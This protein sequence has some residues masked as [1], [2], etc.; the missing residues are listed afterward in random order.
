[1]LLKHHKFASLSA[2]NR[3]VIEWLSAILRVA[4]ALDSS[5]THVVKT[6]KVENQQ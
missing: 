5:H 3:D 1:M 6:N 4:D 2:K